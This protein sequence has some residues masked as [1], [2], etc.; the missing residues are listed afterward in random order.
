MAGN[1]Y[2]RVKR[3]KRYKE[4]KKAMTADLEKAGI[5]RPPYTEWLEDYLALWVEK[6]L[7]E[8]DVAQ[9][10]VKVPYQNGATQKGMTE[11]KSIG[12]KV[13]VLRQMS[14]ILNRLGYQ[15]TARKKAAQAPQNGGEDDEL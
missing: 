7:L 14:D 2:E 3:T 8:E 15:E 10:G 13:L 5:C 1:D 4:L 11:N 6:C 12:A 9:R